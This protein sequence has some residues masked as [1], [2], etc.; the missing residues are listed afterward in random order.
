M[1]Q[2]QLAAHGTAAGEL[3]HCCTATCPLTG[4]V[5]QHSCA[6]RCSPGWRACSPADGA[7]S[8]LGVVGAAQSL[9]SSKPRISVQPGQLD[10]Q[11]ARAFKRQTGHLLLTHSCHAGAE[12]A[13]TGPGQHR[14]KLMSQ[15]STASAIQCEQKSATAA[16]NQASDHGLHPLWRGVLETAPYTPDHDR[17]AG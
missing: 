13:Q 8:S 1:L 3:L 16:P 6:G 15:G 14:V 9:T 4:C 7:S 5:L 17:L 11:M 12:E 10:L 2:Q